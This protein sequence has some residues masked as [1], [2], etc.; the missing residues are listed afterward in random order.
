[1][2]SNSN[3]HKLAVAKFK[4]VKLS[5]PDILSDITYIVRQKKKPHY[6]SSALTGMIPQIAF[7]TEKKVLIKDIRNSI[8]RIT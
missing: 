1:M 2:S 3:E 8:N 5:M 6:E 7:K 4:K